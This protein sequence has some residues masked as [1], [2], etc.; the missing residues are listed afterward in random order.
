MIEKAKAAPWYKQW[1]SY[2]K[3]MFHWLSNVNC[4]VAV[5]GVPKEGKWTGN[6][7]TWSGFETTPLGNSKEAPWPQISLGTEPSVEEAPALQNSV[8]QPSLAS[9]P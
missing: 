4:S 1:K 2:L 8:S 5:S 3:I 6:K 7:T 9:I